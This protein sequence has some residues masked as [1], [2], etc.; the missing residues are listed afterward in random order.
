MAAWQRAP[1]PIREIQYFIGGGINHEK[2]GV[3]AT[4]QDLLAR[5]PVGPFD[6]SLVRVAKSRISN[7]F[8]PTVN[9]NPF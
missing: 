1:A 4:F 7:Y 9:L 8:T 5:H 3:N 2:N 6:F